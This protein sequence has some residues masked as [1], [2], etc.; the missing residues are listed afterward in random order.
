MTDHPSG[1]GAGLPVV[2]GFDGSR[3]AAAA[4]GVAAAEARSRGVPL[5]LV[6]VFTWPWIYPPLVDEVGT[7]R[8]DPR[9]RAREL[10][11]GEAER[12]AKAYPGLEAT[13]R[14]LDG[15]AAAVLVDCTRQAGLL[16]VGHRGA[17]GFTGLLAGSTAIHTAAHAYCPV[18]VVRGD[19]PVPTGPVLVGVDSS[20]GARDA[21][22]YA[23]DLATRHGQPL[24][25]VSVLPRRAA[26]SETTPAL[27]A[28]RDRLAAPAA[29]HPGVEVGTGI[30]HDGTPAGALIEATRAA[31]AVVVGA[32]GVGGLRGMLLGSVGRALI[33]H[34][35]C[36][37][38][39]VRPTATG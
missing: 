12:L 21:V 23:F 30:L 36:P 35:Y 32:R 1:S 5:R 20:D 4:A 39:I 6:H 18:M 29:A 38:V 9:V 27:E 3:P 25:A 13:G 2:V 22:D 28:L 8:G 17:G 24:L 15:S 16:V 19:E 11:T 10:V 37:V 31:S 14:V 7:P 33:E 34:A 26:P